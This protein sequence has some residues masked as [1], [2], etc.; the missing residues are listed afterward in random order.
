MKTDLRFW[1]GVLPV[2]LLCAG[3]LP[4]HG[5][6]T[7]TWDGTGV[8]G[9]TGSA[10]WDTNTGNWSGGVGSSATFNLATNNLDFGAITAGTTVTLGT[11]ASTVQ[12]ITVND[13][14]FADANTA[15]TPT[16]TAA[17]I[18]LNGDNG[19]VAQTTN[20]ATLSLAGNVIVGPPGAALGAG[21]LAT[22]GA[23]LTL[24]LTSAAHSIGAFSTGFGTGTPVGSATI[25]GT[26]ALLINSKIVNSAFTSNTVTFGNSGTYGNANSGLGTSDRTAVILTNN[27]ST[28]DAPISIR[29]N[30]YYTSISN[31]GG[32]PS[33]LGSPSSA[34]STIT[35]VNNGYFGYVGTAN[36][37]VTRNIVYGSSSGIFNDSATPTT[38]D[39]QSLTNNQANAAGSP[40]QLRVDSANAGDVLKISAVIADYDN[41]NNKLLVLAIG[42]QA[43]YD[44]AGVYHTSTSQ[45]AVQLAAANTFSGG[46]Q[47]N[48]GNLQIGNAAALGTGLFAIA[49]GTSFDNV[50]GSAMTLSG[51]NAQSWAGTIS[52]LG[53]SDLN[54]GTGAVALNNATLNVAAHTLT[55][56]GVIS[57]SAKTLTKTG[58]GTL[59]LNGANTYTGATTVSDGVLLLNGANSGT[60][61]VTVKETT[62]GRTTVLG[63][64]GSLAGAATVGGGTGTSAVNAGGVGS[65]GTLSFGAGLTFTTAGQLQF[66]LDSI[67]GTIDSFAVTGTL[68]LGTTAALVGNDLGGGA[69]GLGTVLT[70]ATFTT[71]TGTFAGLADGSTFTLGSNVYQIN[72]G[73]LSGHSNAITLDVTANVVPEPSTWAFL[74]LGVAA[75][76]LLARRARQ[77]ARA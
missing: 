8:S 29:G 68:A 48:S 59:V 30:V 21:Q 34:A 7:I 49:T 75:L 70:L 39:F 37:T 40:A 23:D 72:Y 32:G 65:V 24:S 58:T 60:G 28:F 26:S 51:N 52:Y 6:T 54:M 53:S 22:M 3:F 47:L 71:R 31:I 61:A 16:T 43:Y 13:I 12:T 17:T 14:D 25:A 55:V 44:S 9:G 50:T 15:A 41:A 1:R 62:A 69:L 66:D 64:T 63:G 42:A 45:G 73:T 77:A 76:F 4:A 2:V 27:N 18:L 20:D 35:L 56:G 57:G 5:V 19:G 11:T 38:I 10:F 36:Q 46:T 74:A 67:A 33:A